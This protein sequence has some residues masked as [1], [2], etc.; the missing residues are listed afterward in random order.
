[1]LL[2]VVYFQFPVGFTSCFS[3]MVPMVWSMQVGHKLIVTH[4]GAALD[5]GQSLMSA[6]ALYSLRFI[7]RPD[8][9]LDN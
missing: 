6:V 1:V 7:F 4:Q 2:Y 5:Y 3:I 9:I 8:A